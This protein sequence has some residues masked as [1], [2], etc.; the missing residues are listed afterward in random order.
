MHKYQRL[1]QEVFN[2]IVFCGKIKAR[3][4]ESLITIK[5]SKGGLN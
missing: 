4:N 3:S 5:I 1:K 2:Y